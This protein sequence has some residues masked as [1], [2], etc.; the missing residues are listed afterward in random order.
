MYFLQSESA[1]EHSI[2]LLVPLR[3]RLGDEIS[4]MLDR[5]HV[6]ARW[7]KDTE[8]TNCAVDVQGDVQRRKGRERAEK[9]ESSSVVRE[10]LLVA[11]RLCSEAIRASD[12]ERTQVRAWSSVKGLTRL[13]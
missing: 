6:C 2:Q 5:Q 13:S 3:I 9:A 11:A 4:S 12:K 7:L 8:R 10:W 1:D